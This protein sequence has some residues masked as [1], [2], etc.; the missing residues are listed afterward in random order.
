MVGVGKKQQ[1]QAGRQGGGGEE[2]DN[3]TDRHSAT[4][5][6]ACFCFA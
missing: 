2:E 5:L 4:E 1:Q 3:K 6:F